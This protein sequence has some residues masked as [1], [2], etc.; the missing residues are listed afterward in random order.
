M[1]K[2]SKP[3]RNVQNLNSENFERELVQSTNDVLKISQEQTQ[4]KL[5]FYYTPDFHCTSL[6]ISNERR[7]SM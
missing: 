1:S 5:G 2:Y 7:P 3:K 4:S 6:P